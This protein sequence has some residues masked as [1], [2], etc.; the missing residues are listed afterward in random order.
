MKG[1]ETKPPGINNKRNRGKGGMTRKNL[2][3]MTMMKVVPIEGDLRKVVGKIKWEDDDLG[4]N[5]SKI[6]EFKG[7]NDPEAYLE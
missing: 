6:P 2:K 4:S 5:K 7:R 1:E 3:K